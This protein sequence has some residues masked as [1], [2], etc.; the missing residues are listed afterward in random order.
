MH[1]ISRR[2]ACAG[3][4]SAFAGRGRAQTYP[5]RPLR[6]VIGFTA[7]GASDV[8][9]RTVAQHLGARLGQSVVVENRPG[10]SGVIAADAVAKAAPDGH[11]LLFGLPGPMVI[12]PALGMRLPYDPIKD[13]APV[14]LAGNL[15]L[16]LVVPSALPARNLAELLA[17]ARAQPGR[18]NYAS[19]GAGSTT[20]LG[21]ELLKHAAGVDIR[22]VPYKGQA[23]AL[24]DLLAGEVQMLLAGWS[25]AM[26][27]VRSGRLR[28]I[29]VTGDQRSAI[30]P[31]VPTMA[32]LGVAGVDPSLWCGVWAPAG[33]PEPALARLSEE[34]AAVM[35]SGA[36]RERFGE[37]GM[38]P[39]ASDPVR[40]ARF[41]G[42]EQARWQRVVREAR[43]RLE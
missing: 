1:T 14:G 36:V 15:P 25:T 17:L 12:L 20:H 29:A 28:T 13:F 22:H 32:E 40:F 2:S 3:V 23:A 38:E 43:L 35:Q 41:I 26:P 30:Q 42:S 27:H 33:T 7:S 18:L 37:L 10:A 21:M 5:L 11:T 34:L 19:T 9:A 6:M 24:P 4:L 39:L 16:V 8:M 31:D